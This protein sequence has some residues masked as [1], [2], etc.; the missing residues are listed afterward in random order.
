MT[1]R[2]A[3]V[4]KLDGIFSFYIRLR[5]KY[6][7]GWC[8][9]CGKRPIEICYH[10]IPRGRYATRWLPEAACGGC[11]PCNCGEQF[12]RLMY[13]DKHIALLG[14]EAY[15]ALEAKA[16]ELPKFSRA[17]LQEMCDGFRRKIED[18]R[19]SGKEKP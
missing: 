8:F 1:P 18:L 5:E 10:F 9:V 6:R 17:D 2:K 14:R 3:L 11:K 7:T 15:E 16:R 4:K 13:R 12:H 19:R